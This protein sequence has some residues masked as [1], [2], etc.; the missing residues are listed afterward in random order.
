MGVPSEE[1]IASALMERVAVEILAGAAKKPHVSARAHNRILDAA[2]ARVD[3][4]E[5]RLAAVIETILHKAG[6]RAASLFHERATRHLVPDPTIIASAA[7]ADVAKTATMIALKP[8]PDEAAALAHEGGDPADILHVTLA[9]LGDTDQPLSEIADA[10]KPVVATHGRISG[11]VGGVGVFHPAGVGIALPDVR[12]LTEVRQAVV[13]ALHDNGIDYGRDHGFTPHITIQ[14]DG[15]PPDESLAGQPLHFDSLHIVRGNDEE[16]ELPL[17]GVRALTAAGPN[18]SPPFPD[19]LINVDDLVSQILAKTEPVRKALI[20]ETMTPALEQAGL[21]FDV[22]N[23]LTA[24]LFA[25]TGSQVTNIAMTTRANLMDIIG[26][27]Y[28]NGLTI[29]ATR[30]LIQQ[31]MKA[32]SKTRATMIAR[33]EMARAVNGGSLTAT[34]LVEQETGQAYSKVWHTAPGARYPRHE[35]YPDLDGQ[36]VGTDELFTVGD[37]QLQYPG[38]PNGEPGETINCRCTLSYEEV[39]KQAGVLGKI[40]Q[41]VGSLADDVAGVI[42]TIESDLKRLITDESGAV[43][44]PA[45]NVHVPKPDVVTADVEEAA[46]A[47][48]EG[49]RVELT[50][51]S[52]VNTFIDDLGKMAADA[53]KAGTQAPNL[54]LAKV[55][56]KGTNLFAHDSLGVPRIDMPQLVGIPIPGSPAAALPHQ[57]YEGKDFGWVDI[58]KSFFQSLRDQGIAVTEEEVNPE[59]LRATQDELNGPKIAK[60]MDRLEAETPIPRSTPPPIDFGDAT[61]E[62]RDR[63]QQ[64]VDQAY[65][66]MDQAGI[67]QDW[68]KTL[69]STEQAHMQAPHG[70]ARHPTHIKVVRRGPDYTAEYQTK[71]NSIEINVESRLFPAD[72]YDAATIAKGGTPEFLSRDLADDIIHEYGHS[73]FDTLDISDRGAWRRQWEA[74]QKAGTLPSKYAETNPQE[75]WAETFTGLV[76]KYPQGAELQDYM[77]PVLKEEGILGEPVGIVPSVEGEP[78][79][80]SKDNYILDGHHRWAAA[81]GRDYV[82]GVDVPTPIKVERIDEPITTLL[83]QARDYSKEMGIPPQ[84]AFEATKTAVTPAVPAEAVAPATGTTQSIDIGITPF[85]AATDKAV[86][87]YDSAKY[88]QFINDV[89]QSAEAYGV[90]IDSIEKAT[91]VWEG[92]TEPSVSIHVS[93]TD[94]HPDSEVYKGQ[95]SAPG[96]DYGAPMYDLTGEHGEAQIYPSDVYDQKTQVH[97]YGQGGDAETRAMDQATFNTVNAVKGDPTAMV[98]V[99]RGVPG[100]VTAINP[101]DWVTPSKSYAEQHAESNLGADAH[102]HVISIQVPAGQLWTDGN[103]IQEWGWNP[104][105]FEQFNADQRAR[106]FAA[107]LGKAYNQD[108]VLLFQPQTDGASVMATFR[109]NIPEAQVTKAMEKVGI[110]G[111]RFTTDGRLQIVGERTPEFV[112]Q[113][114]ELGKALASPAEVTTPGSATENTLAFTG[115]YDVQRGD[116]TLMERDSGDY[117]KALDAM[118]HPKGVTTLNV[119]TADAAPSADLPQGDPITGYPKSGGE[120]LT[121]ISKMNSDFLQAAPP[122][123]EWVSQISNNKHQAL[124]VDL[125]VNSSMERAIAEY[126]RDGAADING[127]LSGDITPANFDE[128]AG[129]YSNYRQ[130][131]DAAQQMQQIVDS[132]PPLPEGTTLY[133]GINA[134]AFNPELGD[135]GNAAA[136]KILSAVQ[137]KW[138]LDKIDM[139]YGPEASPEFQKIVTDPEYIK[140]HD[141]AMREAYAARTKPIADW[142]AQEYPVGSYVAM[143]QPGEFESLTLNPNHAARFVASTSAAPDQP[144]LIFK[145]VNAKTGAPMFPFTSFA[146]ESEILAPPD[147]MYRVRSVEL[148]KMDTIAR[149]SPLGDTADRVVVTLEEAPKCGPVTAA[150][151]AAATGVACTNIAQYVPD[152]PKPTVGNA[153][154]FPGQPRDV[155]EAA[156]E[157]RDAKIAEYAKANH[158]SVEDYKAAATEAIRSYIAEHPQIRIRV[159]HQAFEQILDD[160]KFKNEFQIPGVTPDMTKG[161]VEAEKNLFGIPA[162]ASPA[163]RPIYGYLAGTADETGEVQ[164]YG[165][166]IVNLNPSVNARATFTIGDSYSAG[167]NQFLSPSLLANPSI[168]S[169]DGEFDIVKAY[170]EGNIAEIARYVEVEI[171]GGLPLSDVGGIKADQALIVAREDAIRTKEALEAITEIYANNKG[172]QQETTPQVEQAGAPTEKPG[173]F[174]YASALREIGK[175]AGLRQGALADLIARVGLKGFVASDFE[176]FNFLQTLGT[177]NV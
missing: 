89:N 128:K 93:A 117:Q 53:Q 133:R 169:W 2:Q 71:T 114:S 121:Q 90:H 45:V 85:R 160:G 162:G 138:G 125:K 22:S 134:V 140:E 165:D 69:G 15:E 115:D 148:A 54:D 17:V 87:F 59:T 77:R 168:G 76:N 4:L 40:E 137:K 65:A 147:T 80:I 16:V 48:G 3:A 139:P 36:T 86:G 108:G 95:H 154:L 32:A 152:K 58:S 135:A 97:V 172:T 145:I 157:H 31:G 153:V 107:N 92:D 146:D 79:I 120:A 28:Q 41:G 98:T 142:A 33:T 88:Q 150:L 74:A 24:K 136:D 119:P 113:L 56:V 50:N 29:P 143:G 144:G 100:D 116:F 84:S 11:V 67:T 68:A 63:I 55:S 175:N 44:L 75:A 39:P 9:Y 123:K 57:L 49:K 141:E 101:G 167:I 14:G 78:V 131:S 122:Q 27:A 109:E 43:K 8:R 20:E 37:D 61:P 46:K 126:T 164:E 127:V 23:P 42:P 174:D 149:D 62:Q 34:Q 130:A 102:G 96:P 163:D 159:T 132:A 124:G 111:G 166:I 105:D 99:Y 25:D 73:A 94:P 112:K 106:A 60:E 7:N 1:E 64:A 12:G 91:G 158:M 151:F 82:T 38:D 35:L 104:P 161:R 173:Q 66:R 18:W 83:Q 51:A 26:K 155:A 171:H 5:P 70:I 13:Q 118:S 6:T 47:L 30:D 72:Q 177:G 110:S 103:S 176:D 129:Q 52:E 81:V 21:S 19:E 10:L 170:R 156:A